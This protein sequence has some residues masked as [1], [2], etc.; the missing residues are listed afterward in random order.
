M[1]NIVNGTPFLREARA[2]PEE[3]VSLAFQSS[4]AYLE[5]ANAI[6]QRTI[7][8]YPVGKSAITGNGY[9]FSSQKQTGLRQ[10]YAFTTTANIDLGFKL[11]S[12]S[13]IIQMYGTYT[14]GISTFG[15]IAGTSVAIAGQISFFVTVNLASTTSDIIQF[16]VGAGAPALVSGTIVLEWASKSS[17]FL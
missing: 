6:N 4:K 9:Y 10:M 12:L 3:V 16:V 14:D 8:I 2:F 7:G 13:R 11:T 15:L 5:V 17:K 1:T